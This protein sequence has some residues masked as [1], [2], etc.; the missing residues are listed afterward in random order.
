M[1]K[2]EQPTV[3]VPLLSMALLSAVPPSQALPR[4]CVFYA[5][6]P[7]VPSTHRRSPSPLR[8]AYAYDC[9]P[10]SA[11]TGARV[12][13]CTERQRHTIRALLPRAGQTEDWP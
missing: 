11:D 9:S 6:Y 1:E 5:T 2:K 7:P 10:A 12:R 4:G 8:L 13:L 3:A